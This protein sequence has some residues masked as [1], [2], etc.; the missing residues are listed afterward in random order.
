M[1][2][3]LNLP[4]K[5][6]EAWRNF[7]FHTGDAGR[8]GADGYVTFIDRIKDCIRRRGE[9]ISATDIEAVF[10]KLP[11]VSE[12]AAFAVSSGIEGG[13]D[14][15][16]LAI[17]LHPGAPLTADIIVEQARTAMPR[18]ARP[19]YL[20]FRTSLPKTSTEKVRK[21]ELKVLGVTHSTID[22]QGLY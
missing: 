9:N 20:E 12:I 3:Y 18:F 11:G 5:T 22:L 7:W 14:E 10:E 17:V 8:M 6:V 4:A 2:G 21:N 16:M 15:I 1:A 13:E 19:R